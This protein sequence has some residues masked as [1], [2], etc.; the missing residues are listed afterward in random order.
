M[1]LDSSGLTIH[2]DIRKLCRKGRGRNL[3]GKALGSPD[4]PQGT[5]VKGMLGHL[6][7]GDGFSLAGMAKLSTDIEDEL[8]RR[9][10]EN[11]P[12]RL[13]N[14]LPYRLGT[15]LYRPSGDVGGGGSVSP[16][17]EGGGIGI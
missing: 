8:L 11:L 3:S 17:V 14:L 15:A 12:C 6:A 5:A 1:H 9:N 13:G 10:S 2:R 16:H 4:L 7:K